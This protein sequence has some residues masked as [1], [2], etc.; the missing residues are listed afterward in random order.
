MSLFSGKIYDSAPND[1]RCQLQ[2]NS[3][4]LTSAGSVSRT[5]ATTSTGTPF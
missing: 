3:A 5:G 2:K 4:Q 1:R